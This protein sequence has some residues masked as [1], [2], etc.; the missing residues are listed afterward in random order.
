MTAMNWTDI[1]T[2]LLDMDGTLLDLRFDNYFWQEH[3]PAMYAQ[4]LRTDVAE[5]RAKLFSHMKELEGTL[6]W[7][8][9]DYWSASLELDVLGLK[10]ELAHMIGFRPEAQRFLD[11]LGQVDKHRLL[12]TNAHRDVLLLKLEHTLLD[13]HLDEVVSAHDFRKPK[14]DPS[15]W[16]DL[17]QA[18]CFDPARTLL[19]DD[20]PQVLQSA[21]EFGIAHLLGITRPDSTREPKE[22][23]DF[24]AV[25]SFLDILP[26]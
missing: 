20:N 16:D 18:H 13:R 3:L 6:D 9:L 24:P 2:V 15:F 21:R 5:A 22:W 14:E 17:R 10:R 12:V 1:D 23:A 8:C 7:Y 25:E 11:A 26:R 4:R 19:L